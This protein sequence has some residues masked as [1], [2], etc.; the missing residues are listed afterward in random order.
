MQTKASKYWR[1]KVLI[2][3]FDEITS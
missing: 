1:D 2:F 3:V